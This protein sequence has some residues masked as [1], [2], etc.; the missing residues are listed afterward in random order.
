MTEGQRQRQNPHADSAERGRP[1]WGHPSPEIHESAT[2]PSRPGTPKNPV[3]LHV[4]GGPITNLRPEGMIK[5]GGF[6]TF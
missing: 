6:Y 3:L 1:T 2:Q 5:E 4:H